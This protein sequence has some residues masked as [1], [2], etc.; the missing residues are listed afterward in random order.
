MQLQDLVSEPLTK[1]RNLESISHVSTSTVRDVIPGVLE[2][3]CEIV[4]DKEIIDG[5]R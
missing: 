4:R 1:E 2:G 5:F 3:N